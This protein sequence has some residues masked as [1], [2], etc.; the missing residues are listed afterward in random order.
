MRR[1]ADPVIQLL[2]PIA[3]VASRCA[4]RNDRLDIDRDLRDQRAR[5][6]RDRRRAL[7]LHRQLRRPLVRTHQLRRRRC[8]GRRRALDAGGGEARD[9]AEPR[10]PPP[11]PHRRQRLVARARGRRRRCLRARRGPAADAPLRARRR[12]RDVR[13]ARDHPQR[14]PLLGEDRAGAEHVL[15]RSRD[16][17]TA[18]SLGRSR[19]SPSSLRSPTSAAGSAGSSA[20]RA[21]TRPRLARSAC[22]STASG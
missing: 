15:S 10:E 20:R 14:P 9:H 4:R 11:R 6:C 19:R 21:R 2:A 1:A 5:E 3:L 22:P 13:R 8:V 12:D 18:A 16:D 17:R 7:R